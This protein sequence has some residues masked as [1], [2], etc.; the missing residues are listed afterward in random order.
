M[1]FPW[2]FLH[3]SKSEQTVQRMPVPGSISTWQKL[4]VE[5]K[6]GASGLCRWYSTIM[7]LC[8]ARRR[9]SNC[10]N[11]KT[12][13]PALLSAGKYGNKN[14]VCVPGA[15]HGGAV[16]DIPCQQSTLVL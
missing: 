1:P 8:L 2:Q 7:L 3:M 5:E 16:V 4:Q 11:A 15:C 10:G 14:I 9:E 6:A 13:E 12:T